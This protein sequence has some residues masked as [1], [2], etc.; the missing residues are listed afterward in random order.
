MTALRAFGRAAPWEDKK[1]EV[2]PV[3]LQ[4]KSIP[5]MCLLHKILQP[6]RLHFSFYLYPGRCPGLLQC[7]PFGL[8]HNC[9]LDS[10]AKPDEPEAAKCG[11]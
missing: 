6:Y 7:E 11:Y 9:Y 1:I 8:M 5:I 4:W 10:P 2:Q 3:K